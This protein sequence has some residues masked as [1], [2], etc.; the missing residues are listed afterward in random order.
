MTERS[1]T[2]ATF[3]IERTYPASPARV[4][5]AF[6]SRE[7][8]LRWFAGPPE[9]GPSDHE[10]DFRVGGRERVS[11]GPKGGP[12]HIFEARFQDIV[13]N[14]RIITSYDMHLDDKRISVSL[15]T[16]ELKPAGAGTRLIYTEQGAFLDGYDDAGSRE[17]GTRELLANLEA[18]LKREAAGA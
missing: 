11:G 8:K 5:A 16:V 1:V 18:A 14:V 15:A 13:P 17:H 4:F 3:V 7:A 6:A 12:R 9:W 2:H 10:L